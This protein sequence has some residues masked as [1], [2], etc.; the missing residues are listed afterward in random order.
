MYLFF[1]CLYFCFLLTKAN[2]NK[3]PTRCTLT[4]HSVFNTKSD[5][6]ITRIKIKKYFSNIAVKTELVVRLIFFLLLL[7]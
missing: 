5:Y 6:D 4:S 2:K 3:I 7:T 1:N